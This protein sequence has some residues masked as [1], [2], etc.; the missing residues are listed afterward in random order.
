[1]ND[2][3]ASAC[4]ITGFFFEK[5][6]P[7]KG[8]PML[9]KISLFIVLINFFINQAR[10]QHADSLK[11]NAPGTDASKKS[12]AI[13]LKA[14]T[15]RGQKPLIEQRID[16]IVFNAESLPAI[17]GSDAS[18]VLRKVPM[19]SI[20][21]NG[22]LS[23]RG[24][25]NIKVLIDGKPSEIYASA[26]ADALKAIRG[27][28]IVK[29][30]VITN[31]SSRYDAEGTNAVVNIIT[32]KLKAD[33]TNANV[34]GVAGNRSESIGGDV[35]HKRG[36]FLLNGDAFYQKYW[37]GNGSV[38]QR[39]ADH[40]T[41]IQQNETRQSG[42]YF[43][44]GGNLLY[45]LD[46]LNTFNA[47]Y[48][49]RRSPNKTTSISDNYE[50]SNQM[51]EFL[52]QRNMETPNQNKGN[53]Y[54][55]GFTGKSKDQQIAYSILGMYAHFRGTNDY[56]LYQNG[57]GNTEYRENFFSTTIYNDYIIQGDYSQAFTDSWKWEAGAKITA[58]NAQSTSL[59]E[60]YDFITGK[61][62]HDAIR[63]TD[64][65]YKSRIYAGYANMSIQLNKWG[66]SGGIRYEQTAL[67]AVF[68]SQKVRIPSFGNLVPQVLLNRALDDKTNI[69]LGYTMKLVRPYISYLNPTVN[70]SDSLTLQYGNP[71][72]KPELT[73]RYELS[74]SVNDA[75]LFR[76]FVL[77]FNDSRN[78]IENIRFPAGNGIF[79]STWKNVGKDQRLGLAA[80][81]NWKP[82]PALTLGAA[83]TA[84]YVWLESR[85][86]GISNK[87]PMW[88][89]VLNG[90]YKFPHGFNLDFY[91]FFDSN[92]LRLQ[93]YRSGWKFYNMTI[94]KK[95]KN[96]RLN[97]GLRLETFLKSHTYIDEVITTPGYEQRQ[98][99]RYQNQNIRFTFS[100]K[101]GK[102]E[103]K[104]PEIK[105]IDQ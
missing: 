46:S 23:V 104:G 77:F 92:N 52:F 101:I 83:L 48:R 6:L 9:K 56:I 38:L 99:Y 44:G 12:S 81:L 72:L 95:F 68:K 13:K 33:A 100:Y 87:A 64:F 29:V 17:A 105:S 70:T 74:Y 75:T 32:R 28:N 19:L 11:T 55:A 47:G 24:N 62:H 78:T 57:Q 97:L 2:S 30:E 88:R 102:K 31:P 27:E 36:A 80:T 41:L 90:S 54:N 86:L 63:S 43:Y 49:T 16:G 61:Y 96:E 34:S 73:N 91:G 5:K 94:N 4:K 69:R 8:M 89:L 14:V 25:S 10:A 67:D 22:G 40:L 59:F 51:Q 15:I 53:S 84:Q 39:N 42:D 76:D 45:S 60:V 21:G 85:A 20:D 26:V 50:V 3:G 37:N 82:V 98:S 71:Q 18:D 7:H 65:T 93:G 35:H 58:K 103:I 1:M 66:F 79:E